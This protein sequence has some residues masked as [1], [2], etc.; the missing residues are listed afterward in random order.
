MNNCTDL[1]EKGLHYPTSTHTHTHT[2]THVYISIL[3]AVQHYWCHGVFKISA[4]PH[5]PTHTH[6]HTHTHTLCSSLSLSLSFPSVSYT[7]SHRHSQILSIV[8]SSLG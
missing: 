3:P 1:H 7:L 6:T 2:H 4:I 8:G 5:T